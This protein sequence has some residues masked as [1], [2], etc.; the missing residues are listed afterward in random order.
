VAFA[1]EWGMEYFMTSLKVMNLS[2]KQR[3]IKI[4][5]IQVSYKRNQPFFEW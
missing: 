2:K 1:R 4:Y 5:R 3:V